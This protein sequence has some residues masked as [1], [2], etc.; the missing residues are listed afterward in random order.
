MIYVFLADGFEEIEA[1]STVD[2]L[3]RAEAE[4]TTVGVNKK[5]I[6]GA[7]GITVS[8]DKEINECDFLISEALVLPGGMPGT[9][10]LG[11]CQKLRKLLKDSAEKG[12]LLA[13]IC[14]APSVLGD[15]GLLN[16]RNYTC[17]PGFES[18]S[19]GGMYHTDKCVTDKNGSFPLIT[20]KGP[21][22]ANEFAF[23]VT[24]YIKK[25]TSVAERLKKEMQF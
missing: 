4:V 21:G 2:I 16:G 6:T 14:A 11:N 22:A 5:Q 3:R 18:E 24:D 23:A 20:A 19:F 12:I 9:L 25:D 10:N 7:H 13:A 17:Y 1:L 8:T 15:L